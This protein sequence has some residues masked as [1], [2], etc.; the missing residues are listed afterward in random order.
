MLDKQRENPTGGLFFG[1]VDCKKHKQLRYLGNEIT[2]TI[3]VPVDR[4][5]RVWYLQPSRL[6]CRQ[7]LISARLRSHRDMVPSFP[8]SHSWRSLTSRTDRSFIGSH[9]ISARQPRSNHLLSW[10]SLS[11]KKFFFTLLRLFPN[12]LHD[13]SHLFSFHIFIVY[14]FFTLT[15]WKSLIIVCYR[16]SRLKRAFIGFHLA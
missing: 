6:T 12:F 3:V 15:G 4:W 1:K 5:K 10:S 16:D 9:S 8:G 11:F 13:F 2:S 14:L 7:R